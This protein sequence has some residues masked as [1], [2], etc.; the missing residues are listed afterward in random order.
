ME[1]ASTQG[2]ERENGEIRRETSVCKEGVREWVS[3][4]AGELGRFIASARM[5]S[6]AGGPYHGVCALG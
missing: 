2:N 5:G 6:P 4:R 3:G 1:T